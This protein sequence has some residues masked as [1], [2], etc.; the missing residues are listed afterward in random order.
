VNEI[1]IPDIDTIPLPAPIWLLR[2]LSSLTF[3]LHL[4]PMNMILG[5]GILAVAFAWYARARERNDIAR[6]AGHMGATLPTAAAFTIT[7]GVPPLLFLQTLYGPL[8]YTSAVLMA[9]PWLSVVGLLLVGYYSYY[10]FV[11]KR[12]AEGRIPVKAGILAA[13]MYLA[14]SILYSSQMTLMIQPEKFSGMHAADAQGLLLNIGDPMLWPRWLH[15]VVGAI[16][17]SSFTVM[18]IGLMFRRKEPTY[19]GTALRIGGKIF[20]IATIVQMAVGVWQLMSLR[21][22][23]MMMF[24]GGDA[25]A[26][27]VLGAGVL[28]G[29]VATSLV[30]IA[31]RGK[32]AKGNIIA[33]GVAV[34]LTLICMA[35]ARS[36][37]RDAYLADKFVVTAQPTLPNWPVIVLFVLLMLGGIAVVGWMVHAVV[38]KRGMPSS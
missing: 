37:V 1:L 18:T 36:I 34:A 8:F 16:A 5:G 14:I 32:A 9:W 29:I 12:D 11:V 19:G 7:L 35:I 20:V 38:T 26:T 17:V 2:F 31:I 24:L 15:Y 25:H 28:F 21:D 13:L 4:V 33:G 3:I 23:V 10:Y 30:F 6:L 27:G 22:S